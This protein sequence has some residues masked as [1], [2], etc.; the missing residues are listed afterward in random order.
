MK[1]YLFTLTLYVVILAFAAVAGAPG[2]G[3]DI[4]CA[5]NNEP[6]GRELFFKNS[7]GEVVSWSD[8]EDG[9]RVEHYSLRR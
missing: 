1:E 2:I 3:P 5:S 6:P 8:I 4:R 9:G 7:D